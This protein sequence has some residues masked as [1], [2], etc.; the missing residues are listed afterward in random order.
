MKNGKQKLRLMVIWYQDN[1]KKVFKEISQN[2][3]KVANM[4]VKER[5]LSVILKNGREGC[6]ENW[7][8]AQIKW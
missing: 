7:E 4:A 8:K 3:H 5:M 2:S 1:S 6:K